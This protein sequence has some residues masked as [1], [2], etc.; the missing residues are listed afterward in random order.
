MSRIGQKPIVIPKEVNVE[1]KEGVIFVEGKKGKLE[2]KLSARVTVEIKDGQLFVKRVANTKMDRA[3]HGLYRALILNM[4]IGVSEGYLKELEIQG[5]GF[6]AAVQGNVLNM[7]LGFSHPVNI[8]IPAG[9]K[10]ETPKPTQII[11]RGIDKELVG[12]IASEIHDVF[13]PEPY[14]GKGIRFVGEHVKK[15]VGK[16]KATGK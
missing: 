12:K 2:R 1:V 6:R 15:K 8:D 11:I 16:A 3:F 5:V 9:L 4:I 10:I 14:K 13:P 7:A